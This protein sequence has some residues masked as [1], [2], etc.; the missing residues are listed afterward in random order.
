MREGVPDGLLAS[1]QLKT[2]NGIEVSRTSYL[3]GEMA[4]PPIRGHLVN[5]HLGGTGWLTTVLDGVTWERS[6]VVGAVE[7]FSGGRP[8]QR[9]LTGTV[10]DDV[11]V[12]LGEGLLRRI[13]NES[14][15]DPDGVE[16]LEDL[17]GRDPQVER[18]LLSFLPE[19]ETGGLGGELYAESLANVLAVHLLRRY[20]S[21]GAGDRRIVS[22]GPS[23]RLSGR[24]LK[25]AADFIGDNLAS[26]LSLEEISAAASVSPRHLSRLF[27]DATGLS[28][29]QY[30]IRERVE[31]AR[32]LLAGT[33]LPVGEV[34]LVV[35]FAHQGH[36][37]RHFVRLVGLSPARFR[38]GSR[39]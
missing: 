5:L 27:K 10:S 38:R 7:V 6:Q 15:A 36:L 28:P 37:A 34:A 19:L 13:A 11:N 12:S 26:S 32:E 39:R 2:F 21:L 8:Q 24:A 4:V 33:D 23:G 22:R 16:I 18:V 31:K 17:D 14:G 25:R 3:P 20:S 35:G 30:V 1:R 9:A 29:H